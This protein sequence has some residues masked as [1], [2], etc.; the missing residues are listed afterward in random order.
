MNMYKRT[1]LTALAA[2]SAVMTACGS[3]ENSRLQTFFGPHN[4][5][6]IETSR[7]ASTPSAQNVGAVF[8]MLVDDT[9][10]SVSIIKHCSAIQI[11]PRYVLTNAHCMQKKSETEYV[12]FYFSK[13]FVAEDGE[14]GRSVINDLAGEIYFTF[15]G[16]TL[17]SQ[18]EG[19]L[20]NLKVH[21]VE[22]R[23]DYA[24]LEITDPNFDDHHIDIDQIEAPEVGMELNLLGYP[25][26]LPLTRTTDCRINA[27]GINEIKHDCDSAG[28]SS[29][30][31]VFDA[32]TGAAVALHRQ[33]VFENSYAFYK[34]HGRS[35]TTLE[36][37]ERECSEK[38]KL[39]KGSEQFQ[40]CV[41]LR[42]EKFL[43]NRAIPLNSIIADLK[44]KGVAFDSKKNSEVL[45]YVDRPCISLEQLS[46]DEK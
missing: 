24:L 21:T 17:L 14:S 40:Q 31:L 1:I 32:K 43:F 11:S 13:D 12:D 28:G 46:C 9:G 33:G 44:E 42:S 45:K 7:L 16:K 4:I 25:N 26:G 22:T 18:R 38:Y 15:E 8:L 37:A 35:E 23:L 10:K 29:G 27:T 5:E 6:V 2:S 41:A 34:D 3:P 30:G 20:P 39:E 36:L 19:L